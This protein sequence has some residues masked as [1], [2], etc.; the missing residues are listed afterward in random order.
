[1]N[2]LNVTEKIIRRSHRHLL[3]K[4]IFVVEVV[5]LPPLSKL[6]EMVIA[7]TGMVFLSFPVFLGLALRKL[8]S[9]K[10]IF[11]KAMI[12]GINGQ[13]I[14]VFLFNTEKKFLASLALIFSI[15]SR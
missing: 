7:M 3:R 8:F 5:I 6:A 2:D 12:I 9:G 15:F 14:V 10:K 13:P 1:M 4:T 11:R